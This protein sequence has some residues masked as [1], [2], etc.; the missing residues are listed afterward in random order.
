MKTS[1]LVNMINDELKLVS[2]DSSFTLE[3]ILFLCSKYRAYLIQTDNLNKKLL[4]YIGYDSPLYQTIC[5][6]LEEVSPSNNGESYSCDGGTVLKSTNI[7]P[8]SLSKIKVNLN[9]FFKSSNL[10]YTNP[11]RLKYQGCNKWLNNII[12][13]AIHPNGYLYLKSGNSQFKY[14][15]NVTVTGIFSD[16]EK[17]R[18]YDC[19]NTDSPCDFMEDEYPIEDWMVPAIIQYVVQDLS[20]SIYRPADNRNNA[21][22]DLNDANQLPD[23]NKEKDEK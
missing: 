22:D 14:L 3:H 5:V 18:E 7:V 21:A 17:A 9:N 15:E 13:A 23:N 20:N 4:T 2:D 10:V 8:S 6:N 1:E 11:E 19:Y 16:P 12:Y